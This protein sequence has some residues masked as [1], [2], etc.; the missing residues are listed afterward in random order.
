M[1]MAGATALVVLVAAPRAHAVDI[2]HD[3]P[4]DGAAAGASSHHYKSPQHFAFELKF[5][6][7]RPDVDSEFDRGGKQLRR[8]YHDFYGDGRK[9]LT[10][11]EFDWQV[12][13]TFGSL[14]I[15]ASLGYFSI[16]AAAPLG[17]GTGALSGDQSQMKIVPTSISAI[18]RFDYFLETRDFPLVPYGKVGLDYAYWQITDG[19]SDIATDGM[20]GTGRGGTPGWHASLGA[21]LVLDFFDP[22]AARDF[23]ADMGVNHT[24]LTFEYA[25]SDLSGLGTKNRLHVGDTT[26]SLGLLLEF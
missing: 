4:D 12:L 5:G 7:Y 23:D 2:L 18:Y 24:A 14:A 20:G 8:P 17:S 22:E 9:L 19:N 21:A 15:G 3:E 26:W 25:H 6:P 10:Q 13:H 1:T 16:S 11:I